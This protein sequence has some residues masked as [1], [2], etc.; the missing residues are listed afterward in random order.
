MTQDSKPQRP[1]FFF[2]PARSP[3]PFLQPHRPELW[4]KSAFAYWHIAALFPVLKK[5]RPPGSGFPSFLLWALP[6][7]RRARKSPHSATNIGVIESLNTPRFP[8]P[9]YPLA[10]LGSFFSLLTPHFERVSDA[11]NSKRV[12]CS[13][14]YWPR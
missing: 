1:P 8:L 11:S 12:F 3:P 14:E 7:G 9:S 6:F 5:T 13:K 2:F 10:N 4:L